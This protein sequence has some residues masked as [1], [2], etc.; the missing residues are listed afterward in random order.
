[1]KLLFYFKVTYWRWDIDEIIND[2]QP[3]NDVIVV[4]TYDDAFLHL[5]NIDILVVTSEASNIIPMIFEKCPTFFINKKLIIIR[6]ITSWDI[7]HFVMKIPIHLNNIYTTLNPMLLDAS[8][9]II[10]PNHYRTE[11]INFILKLQSLQN[12]ERLP[13]FKHSNIPRIS[14]SEFY[15]KYNLDASKDIITIYIAFPKNFKV[16]KD[17]DPL[18]NSVIE[19]NLVNNPLLLESLIIEFEKKYNVVFKSHPLF[20]MKFN[21]FIAGDIWEKSCEKRS[22]VTLD[23]M[24]PLINKY[25]FID[26]NDGHDLNLLTHMGVVLSR[27]TFGFNNYMFNIPLLYVSN[28]DKILQKQYN[29]DLQNRCNLDDVCYGEFTTIEEIETNMSAVVNNFIDKFNN[30]PPFKHIHENILYGNT[31]DHRP[32]IW[33]DYIKRICKKPIK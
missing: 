29:I 4:N 10:L 17:Q 15:K 3:N 23:I 19:T 24:K 9:N 2:L 33:I 28:N 32:E 16:V 31:F 27:T 30:K 22:A 25:T 21:P 13:V 6:T 7:M 12:V 26:M 11:N 18:M 8:N 5:P 1:M 20:K 14:K